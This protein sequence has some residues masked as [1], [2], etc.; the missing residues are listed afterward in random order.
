MA[1]TVTNMKVLQH[2]SISK[3]RPD[4]HIVKRYSNFEVI[5]CKM[6]W[7]T[8]ADK[9][10]HKV[11]CPNNFPTANKDNKKMISQVQELR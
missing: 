10:D 8:T 4:S 1:I 7:K 2:N 3:L 9:K 6:Y 11:V 5:Y